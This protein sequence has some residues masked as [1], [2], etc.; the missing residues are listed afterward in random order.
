MTNRKHVN[1]FVRN[2]PSGAMCSSVIH[3]WAKD[4]Y[5]SVT[6]CYC[7]NGEV[8]EK[9]HELCKL[10]RLADS[11][12]V[13][14]CTYREIMIID[15][16]P[17]KQSLNKMKL[18]ENTHTM[19]YTPRITSSDCVCYIEKRHFGFFKHKWLYG[20]RSMYDALHCQL[21]NQMD[22][23]ILKDFLL[24]RGADELE[25]LITAYVHDLKPPH[26]FNAFDMIDYYFS[27]FQRRNRDDSNQ[28]A[29]V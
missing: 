18:L 3:E 21:D 25:Q 11:E 16:W 19:V 12:G 4:K 27:V 8:D 20:Y 24:L 13:N 29:S 22:W 17:S 9:I 14:P 6:A 1:L 2:V 10:V 5:D 26:E 15:M 23:N 7:D 28:T